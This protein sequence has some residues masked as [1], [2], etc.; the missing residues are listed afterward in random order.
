MNETQKTRKTVSTAIVI[1][2]VIIAGTLALTRTGTTGTPEPT[3]ANVTAPQ[4]NT[5]KAPP[6]LAA[7]DEQLPP[8]HPAIPAGHP[9]MGNAAGMGALS[10]ET[11][12][13]GVTWTAPPRWEKVPHASSMR[14]ATY[15]IPHVAGDAE[16]A[17]LSVTR[18]GG[19]TDA[20]IDRWLGQFDEAGR[21][22]AKRTE[23]MVDGLR[24][25][26]VEIEGEYSGMGSPEPAPGYAMKSAIVET[27]G[28]KHFF[29][30]TGPA[31]TVEAARAELVSLVDSVRV[32]ASASP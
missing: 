24:V 3:T 4:A 20:N 15:R 26:L 14:I 29:K 7:G 11:P 6:A 13:A 1:G 2:A 32:V 21:K 27:A 18:A 16:D 28:T 5:T 23:R 10:A 19:D 17:E 9:A 31:K 8:G 12:T 30:L 25:I 22:T